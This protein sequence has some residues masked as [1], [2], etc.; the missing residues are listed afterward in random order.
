MPLLVTGHDGANLSSNSSATQRINHDIVEGRGNPPENPDEDEETHLVPRN[1][2]RGGE[3]EAEP[4]T[5]ATEIIPRPI[6]I[7][8]HLE[9][10]PYKDR[11]PEV[12]EE[13]EFVLSSFKGKRIFGIIQ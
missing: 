7:I 2:G 12:E 11:R 13:E 6:E 10:R 4:N 5:E 9:G 8:V 3:I 1:R